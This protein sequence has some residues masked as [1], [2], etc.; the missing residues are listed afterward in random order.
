MKLR[1]LVPETNRDFN[2]GFVIDPSD[3]LSAQYCDAVLR[4]IL[5]LPNW[6]RDAKDSGGNTLG[7]LL[8]PLRSRLHHAAKVWAG[9]DQERERAL[10]RGNMNLP[11]SLVYL[12]PLEEA[13]REAYVGPPRAR[14]EPPK[15]PKLPTAEAT[16]RSLQ[17]A[18]N[19]EEVKR[20]LQA[21][22]NVNAILDTE[23][24]GTAAHVCARRMRAIMGEMS[25][26]GGLKFV[27][28]RAVDEAAD[29]YHAV[30]DFVLGLK[31]W[32]RSTEDKAGDTLDMAF[33]AVRERMQDYVEATGRDGKKFWKGA[34][35]LE[36]SLFA[37]WW[38]QYA[39]GKAYE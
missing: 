6:D 2:L 12:L 27:F 19:L 9:G 22:D 4:F 3:K 25:R 31:K 18:E 7:Q 29:Y 36:G 11:G 23:T 20:W 30:L 21:G 35:R 1:A 10:F 34:Q 8:E 15:A 39:V 17:N 38:A 24:G 28:D 26:T 5:A 16:L 32:D 33:G 14:I 37:F 13:V